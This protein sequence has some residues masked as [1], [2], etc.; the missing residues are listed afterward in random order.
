MVFTVEIQCVIFFIIK[1]KIRNELKLVCLR[2]TLD[3]T[4]YKK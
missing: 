1:S 2:I 4:L 3:A